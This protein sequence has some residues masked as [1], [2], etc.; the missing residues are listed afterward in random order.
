MDEIF[1]IYL[2]N[3]RFFLINSKNMGI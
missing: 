3:W 2:S 1:F